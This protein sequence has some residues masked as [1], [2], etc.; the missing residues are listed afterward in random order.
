MLFDI[1]G[2]VTSLLS[3]YFFI[4]VSNKAWPIGLLAIVM[5]SYLYWQ[6]GIYADMCLELFYFVSLSYGWYRWVKQSNQPTLAIRNTTGKEWL[7]LV[8]ITAILYCS[9]YYAL[10]TFTHSTIAKLDACTTALSIVGQVLMCHKIM[11][12]WVFWFLAD[13]CYAYLYLVKNLP[14]HGLLMVV[15][16]GMAVTGYLHWYTLLTGQ[17]V[18]WLRLQSFRNNNN[19]IQ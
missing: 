13:A 10:T 5:N 18:P 14:Y 2:A 8:L 1:L 15:Y 9:I 6:K 16:T 7:W 3:T 17:P 12:T 19:F 4:R 11:A